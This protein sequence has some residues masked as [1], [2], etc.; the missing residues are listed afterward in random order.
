MKSFEKG[1]SDQMVLVTNITF[2]SLCEHHFLPFT[3]TVD[4]GYLPGDRIAGLSKFARVVDHFAAKP[5]TQELMTAD[6]AD[7]MYTQLE[8][9]GV[10]VVARAEHMCMSC[11][12]VRKAGSV[13]VTSA[14]RGDFDKSEYLDLLRV[15]K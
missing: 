3:G 1:D 15:V 10:M 9:F 11:R 5:Q 12:G 4:V 2:N 7:Y 14:I 13:T 8:A 6:L